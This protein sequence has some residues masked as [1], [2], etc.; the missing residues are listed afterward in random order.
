MHSFVPALDTPR[1][2]LTDVAAALGITTA[3]IKRML[4]SLGL[5]DQKAT[6][7][8][9]KRFTLRG[10]L[11]IA[12]AAKAQS[13]GLDPGVTGLI[14]RNFADGSPRDRPWLES[15]Q[16]SFIILFTETNEFR[17]GSPGNLTLKEILTPSGGLARAFV[18]LNCA[19][20]IQRV[21]ERLARCEATREL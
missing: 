8:V 6:K 10:V 12:L 17:F 18:V 7:G 13:F 3:E 16:P 2:S 11:S 20:M 4:I 5:Y 14:A 19:L 1:Y 15:P 9:R 21:K